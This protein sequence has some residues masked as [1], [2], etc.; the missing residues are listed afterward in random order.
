MK[1]NKSTWI[2]TNIA[3]TSQLI[4]TKFGLQTNTRHRVTGGQKQHFLEIQDSGACHLGF[5]F[6]HNVV[7]NKENCIKIAD[8]YRP[9]SPQPKITLMVKYWMAVAAILDSV[10]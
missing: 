9:R 3:A 7:A 5:V 6:G 1:N 8:R 10:F 4:S 2:Y